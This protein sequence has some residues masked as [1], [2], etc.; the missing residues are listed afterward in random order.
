MSTTYQNRVNIPPRL[1]LKIE[2]IDKTI[3]NKYN[4]Y[5]QKG[6]FQPKMM[7]QQRI[8][9][10]RKYRFLYT[11]FDDHPGWLEYFMKNI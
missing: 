2:E 4:F 11:W 8:F 6:M 9:G 1:V 7:F 10:D 3:G 5:L